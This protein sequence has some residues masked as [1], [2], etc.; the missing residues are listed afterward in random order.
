MLLISGEVNTSEISPTAG[1]HH[2]VVSEMKHMV[3][4]LYLLF[5]QQS[6]DPFILTRCE[7]KV[8]P[9]LILT[10]ADQNISKVNS[11]EMDINS[12]LQKKYSRAVHICGDNVHSIRPKY[13]LKTYDMPGTELSASVQSC[14]KMDKIPAFMELK[15]WY[16]RQTVTK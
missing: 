7:R 13:L 3:L 1:K 12:D 2:P 6:L 5:L 16:R 9:F 14:G 11:T 4:K 8:G 10:T 15:V